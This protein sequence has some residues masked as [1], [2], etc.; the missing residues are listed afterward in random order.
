MI[1]LDTIGQEALPVSAFWLNLPSVNASYQIKLAQEETVG[2]IFAQ[3]NFDRNSA[4]S[5]LAAIRFILTN[6]VRHNVAQDVLAQELLQ[7]GLPKEHSNMVCKVFTEYYE[8]LREFHRTRSLR[9]NQFEDLVCE[10]TESP[11]Y[12]DI[13][14]VTKHEILN[15]KEHLRTEHRLSIQKQDLKDL[16]RELEMA[17]AVME[18]FVEKLSKWSNYFNYVIYTLMSINAIYSGWTCVK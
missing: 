13:T 7:L 9:I 2:M 18:P 8:N 5:A 15:E 17:R 3:Q 6:T 14:L 12:K 16:V 10:D 11:N 1:T 4:K